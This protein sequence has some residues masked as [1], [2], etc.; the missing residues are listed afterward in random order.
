MKLLRRL[1][2]VLLVLLVVAAALSWAPDR[3][4]ASLLARWAGAPSQFIAL[5]GMQV[6]LRD[7]G[8]KDDPLPLL[9]LHGTSASLHTWDG[10]VA[11]LAGQR[12]VIR[13]D[14]PGFGLTGPRPDGD[15][16]IA[17]YVQ[18]VSHLLD[19]QQLQQVVL[20]G[21]SLGGEIAWMS[22][23][24]EPQRVSRLVLIDAAGYPIAATSIPLGFRIA[25]TPGLN[26]VVRWLLPRSV[27]SDSLHNTYGDPT[28]VSEELIDR[29]YELS[30]R[31]GNRDA[32]IA[33][34]QQMTP[35]SES[36][37]IASI[38]QPTLILWGGRDRL[39][40][41]TQGELFEQAIRGSQRVV[42]PELG[43]V[44]H[45]EDPRSTLNAVRKFMAVEIVD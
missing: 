4:V 11:G 44:P 43:H 28:K 45:E 5:D 36:A 32:L 8:P 35:G 17:A 22:A 34:F 20:V 25:A 7:E 1:A 37:R 39:I 19:Q 14:L 12:R 42:F 9:L 31:A 13:V 21:N 26:Q 38:T 40:P 33:R 18:F 3:P 30:L 6:H 16:R 23:L 15:Y 41:P 27:V 24:A 10:W 2:L 29:Y